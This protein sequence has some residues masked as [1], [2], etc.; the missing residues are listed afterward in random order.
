MAERA[1][2]PPEMQT[3]LKSMGLLHALDDT[4]RDALANLPFRIAVVESGG[5]VVRE[6][7]RPNESCL[8]I[9]GFMCRY[10]HSLSGSRQILS[11]HFPG[12]IPDLQSIYLARMDHSL[13][14]L[15]RSRVA[16][17]PHEAI[18]D[19]IRTNPTLTSGLWKSTLVD[20]A[21]FRAWLLNVGS[22]PA[23]Q[24][25]AHLF[26]EI[27]LRMR[28]LGLAEGDTF[29]LPLTQVVLAEA[30]ALSVVHVNRTLQELRREGVITARS[31]HFVIKDW[32]RLRHIGEFDPAYLH[33]SADLPEFAR[34]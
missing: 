34:N 12:D 14:A 33:Y 28:M 8:V 16:L 13:S 9:D 2:R 31:G 32:Q 7:Q 1:D 25:M 27:F 21:M 19:A 18:L 29:V 6:G 4:A 26:C 15:S 5:D 23:T 11:F 20:A 24:R 3:L 17:I 30:L 10:K 22:K